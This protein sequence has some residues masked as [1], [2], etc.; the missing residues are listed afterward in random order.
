MLPSHAKFKG[1]NVSNVIAPTNSNTIE[2]LVNAA[3]LM[4]KSTHLDWKPRKTNCAPIHSNALTAR[5]TIKLIPTN[6]H[7]GDINSTENST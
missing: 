7:F 1:P 2:N 4:P 6:V 3:R 5:A